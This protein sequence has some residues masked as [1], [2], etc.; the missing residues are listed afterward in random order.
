MQRHFVAVI[1]IVN[2]ALAVC[3]IRVDRFR[4]V[5]TH[6]FPL[7]RSGKLDSTFSFSAAKLPL[8]VFETMCGI[9]GMFK[10]AID[11]VVDAPT[12]HRMCQTIIHRGPDD[13]GI[14]LKDGVGLGMRRLS[15]IDLSGGRQPIHNEDKTVWVVFNGEIY[16]FR[17]LRAELE[18]GGHRFY[19]N[20][21]TEVIVHLYE[22]LGSDFVLKLRGMFAIAL[23]DERRRSFG[24]GSGSLR[25]KAA[26]LFV[27]CGAISVVRLRDQVAASRSTGVGRSRSRGYFTVFLLRIYP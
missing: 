10:T 2:I 24:F 26:A 5:Q 1:E 3:D 25:Q 18:R 27:R 17:E 6:R 19:T 23:Y 8:G 20:T 21:D 9:A 7:L 12:I 11:A 13:E 15:I 4:S 16:N 22:D 14:Y